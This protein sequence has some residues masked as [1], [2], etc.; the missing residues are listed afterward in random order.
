MCNQSRQTNKY[1]YVVIISS[2][3]V[4]LANSAYIIYI[5]SLYTCIWHGSHSLSYYCWYH[6][7]YS[8]ERIIIIIIV[9]RVYCCAAANRRDYTTAPNNNVIMC[10]LWLCLM[11][12]YWFLWLCPLS[13]SLRVKCCKT[14]SEINAWICMYTEN[15]CCV[16]EKALFA[17]SSCV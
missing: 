3:S 16:W 1:T 15:S 2:F 7:H 6:C 8:Y 11:W 14:N 17:S 5:A 9:I 12:T 13:L 10:V 4:D